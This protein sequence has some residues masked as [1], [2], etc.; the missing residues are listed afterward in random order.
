MHKKSAYNPDKH[1][2]RSIRLK[3]YDYSSAGLYFITIC[4]QNRISRFGHIEN[5]TMILNEFGRVANDEWLNTPYI[6]KNI[7]LG[8]FIIM[9]NHMH[10]I[11]R[12]LH[13]AEFNLPNSTGELHSPQSIELNPP[14]SIELNSP[15]SIE[16]HSP[17]SIEMDS[18][19]SKELNQSDHEG[20][21]KT[22]PQSPQPRQSRHTPQSPSQTI[23]AIIRGYKSSVT[24]QLKSLG[25]NDKLWQR[26]YHEHIIRN[27]KAHENI[28]NYIINNPQKWDNDKFYNK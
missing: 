15:Q 8:E 21:C 6:R 12:I 16:L 19:Q 20:V 26:N 4:C 10:G 5:G 27:D 13:A 3:G 24:K 17:K 22:P 25:L 28:S 14:Q 1:N 18:P 11:I 2:R 7:Q 9:P 23:G